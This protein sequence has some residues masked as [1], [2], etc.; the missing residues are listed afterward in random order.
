MDPRWKRVFASVESVYIGVPRNCA[1]FEF[2]MTIEI[3]GQVV[4][5]KH[6]RSAWEV[7]NN[8]DYCHVLDMMVDAIDE[9]L[10]QYDLIKT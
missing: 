8:R 4:S 6:L 5:L 7:K 2:R 10:D 3:D 1:G 9:E